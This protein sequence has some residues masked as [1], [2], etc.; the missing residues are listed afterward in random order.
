[1][2]HQTLKL[3]EKFDLVFTVKERDLRSICNILEENDAPNDF[4]TSAIG[5]TQ[6][7]VYSLCFRKAAVIKKILKDHRITTY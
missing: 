3:N 4:T 6:F 2:S 7:I 1:M 5:G